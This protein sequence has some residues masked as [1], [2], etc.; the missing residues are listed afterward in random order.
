[1]IGAETQAKSI[2]KPGHSPAT[3]EPNVIYTSDP[4]S[5]EL[6]FK[7]PCKIDTKKTTIVL[8]D[9]PHHKTKGRVTY[10]LKYESVQALAP[11][12]ISCQINIGG[13]NPMSKRK[14]AESASI[15]TEPESHEW[16]ISRRDQRAAIAQDDHLKAMLASG[17]LIVG[18]PLFEDS[19]LRPHG[20]VIEKGIHAVGVPL[21][22]W[23][24]IASAHCIKGEVHKS[25]GGAAAHDSDTNFEL[26]IPKFDATG[27]LS[28]EVKAINHRIDQV[29]QAESKTFISHRKDSTQNNLG[30]TR[31]GSASI[32]SRPKSALAC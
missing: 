5:I 2:L 31:K 1:M 32:A 21:S 3:S 30:V 15:T 13:G 29:N 9:L 4:V 23:R 28:D 18:D 10:I 12:L 16:L 27:E 8:D 7:D 22:R 26:V 14:H 24:L 25:D 11:L 19:D 17:Q 6:K 20:N